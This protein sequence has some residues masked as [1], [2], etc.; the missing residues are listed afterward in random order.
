MFNKI[1]DLKH[2]IDFNIKNSNDSIAIEYLIDN[3]YQLFIENYTEF[4]LNLETIK[5]F[6][7]LDEN[8]KN[9]LIAINLLINNNKNYVFEENDQ[10]YEVLQNMLD[11]INIL[12]LNNDNKKDEFYDNY[13]HYKGLKI[14]NRKSI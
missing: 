9:K 1:I 7:Y 11:I 4:N 12:I 2:V 13:L 6:K 8:K 5:N 10:Y 14:V 3:N